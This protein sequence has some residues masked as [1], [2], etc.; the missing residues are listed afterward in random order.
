[1]VGCWMLTAAIRVWIWPR[2]KYAD[3]YPVF[4]KPVGPD[5]VGSI[6]GVDITASSLELL[7]SDLDPKDIHPAADILAA[8][9]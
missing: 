7:R 8:G 5:V 9:M 1:M 4:I 6:F 3:I 2:V